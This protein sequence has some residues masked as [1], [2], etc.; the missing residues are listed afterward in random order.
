MNKTQFQYDSNGSLNKILFSNDK[1]LKRKGPT[2]QPG[3]QALV[4]YKPTMKIGPDPLMM[5]FSAERAFDIWD[6]LDS[7]GDPIGNTKEMNILLLMDGVLLIEKPHIVE[8]A[9]ST[10]I[11]IDRFGN[12]ET[13]TSICIG[14][15][16]SKGGILRSLDL[17]KSWI[18][19]SS[20]GKTVSVSGALIR[21]KSGDKCV[22]LISSEIE[23]PFLLCPLKG[24]LFSLFFEI[25]T[26]IGDCFMH[27]NLTYDMLS[28]SAQNTPWVFY[29]DP[30]GSAVIVDRNNL[31]N[32]F[33]SKDGVTWLTPISYGSYTLSG[34][35][36]V[37]DIGGISFHL[38]YDNQSS[39]NLMPIKVQLMENGVVIFK[40][41]N[42]NVI[43]AGVL[44]KRND[45]GF[46]MTVYFEG[47]PTDYTLWLNTKGK[48]ALV[49][50]GNRL[51][52]SSENGHFW[53]LPAG[54][55]LPG[56]PVFNKDGSLRFD[57]FQQR[58]GKLQP[59][60]SYSW[61]DNMLVLQDY[62]DGSIWT[63]NNGKQWRLPNGSEVTG[64]M[65]MKMEGPIFTS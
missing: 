6:V 31:E 9:P 38:M 50:S 43:F 14:V 12:V 3:M 41:D 53:E 28:P 55:R 45:G 59:T 23:T 24:K 56:Q 22:R 29:L 35:C 65:Q 48:M 42:E 1:I 62:N 51:I 2:Q 27:E 34:S 39:W 19:R 7:A 10:I 47:K 44:Q 52:M 21:S 4:S 37:D 49:G 54:I 60:F 25:G 8:G 26:K 36:Y 63:S 16:N 30:G 46:V 40:N 20:D 32:K 15:L 17:G 61:K 5:D 58:R 11:S 33:Q 13:K 18:I 57:V 64:K